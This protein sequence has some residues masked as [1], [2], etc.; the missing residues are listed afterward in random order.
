MAAEGADF[1]WIDSERL[2]RFGVGVVDSAADL[3][4]QRGFVRY[5]LLTTDRA[6]A[7]ARHLAQGAE[8]VLFVAPTPVPEAAASARDE[9]GGR[10]LVA[11]GGGR[12]IDA[13]KA[14]AGADR[15]PVAAI[16]TTLSGAE[17]T[18]IHRMPAGVTEFNLVRPSLVIADPRLMASQPMPDIA[19]SAMNALA[20]GMEP[21]YTPFANP[22]AEMTALRGARLIAAALE[23]D[24]EPDRNDLALGSLL[25]AYALDSAG[26]AVH[27]VV[28]QTIVRIA[29]TPH[30]QTN[31]VMLP[32]TMAFMASRAPGAIGRLASALR[33]GREDPALAPEEAVRLAARSGATRLSGIGFDEGRI[34][35][36]V[37]AA[38][39][40]PELA[41]T[42]PS[43]PTG[44][45]LERVIRH[46]L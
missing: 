25:C 39:A 29:L 40:R 31:A 22:V 15:L 20:H 35:E 4:E 18:Q 38:L 12:V 14:I 42:P 1:T 9:V 3:L 34:D 2:I 8:S 44:E 36:V 32:H 13:A 21:L 28:C 6:L 16:P 10:P 27:H 26:Y 19:A 24:G 17:M 30:A 23:G 46:A 41:N 37:A 11:L 45:E 7:S 5:A 33:A 43:P